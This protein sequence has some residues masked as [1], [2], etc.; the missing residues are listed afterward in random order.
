MRLR[1]CEV[2]LIV[3][4][5]CCHLSPAL[6]LGHTVKTQS[7]SHWLHFIIL[8]ERERESFCKKCLNLF[9]VPLY[10]YM[11]LITGTLLYPLTLPPYLVPFFALSITCIVRYH[12]SLP[13]YLPYPPHP[14]NP[15]GELY[16]PYPLIPSCLLSLGTYPSSKLSSSHLPKHHLIAPHN[17]QTNT[18]NSLTQRRD[19]R[20]VAF[21]GSPRDRQTDK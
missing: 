21:L 11:Y 4:V 19:G 2:S 14:T 5:T 16:P 7:Q 20:H 8:R 15:P 10:L 1:G 18:N 6:S 12:P 13:L 17:T 3:V 9:L